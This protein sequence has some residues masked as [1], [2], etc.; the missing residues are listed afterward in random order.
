M[1]VLLFVA[2]IYALRFVY[3]FTLSYLRQVVRGEEETRWPR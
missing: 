1:S 3:V 2:A